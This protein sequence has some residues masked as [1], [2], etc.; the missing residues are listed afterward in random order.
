MEKLYAGYIT[1]KE[2]EAVPE[3]VPQVD[4]HLVNED[5]AVVVKQLTLDPTVHISTISLSA[6]SSEQIAKQRHPQIIRIS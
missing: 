4:E 5:L 3:A 2:H 6:I 1:I